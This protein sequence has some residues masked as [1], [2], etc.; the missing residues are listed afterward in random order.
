MEKEFPNNNNKK[1]KPI[2][3]EHK[4]KNLHKCDCNS[5][6]MYHIE[7]L[8]LSNPT[9]AEHFFRIFTFPL[10]ILGGKSRSMADKMNITLILIVLVIR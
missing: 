6:P 3:I 2:H 8:L 9:F 5:I 1:I 10:H 4:L 7:I